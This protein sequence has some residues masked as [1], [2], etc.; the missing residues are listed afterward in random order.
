ME[1]EVNYRPCQCPKCQHTLALGQPV[2]LVGQRES[3]K[4]LAKDYEQIWIDSYFH[5]RCAARRTEWMAKWERYSRA[6]TRHS[7]A[8]PD[9]LYNPADRRGFFTDIQVETLAQDDRNCSICYE[10]M[11][12]EVAKIPC[13]HRFHFKC[14]EDWFHGTNLDKEIKASCPLCRKNW[15]GAL[16]RIPSW[17]DPVY[18]P[19]EGVED[20]PEMRSRRQ[21]G[22]YV[23]WPP[24]RGEGAIPQLIRFWDE[25]DE[26]E[27]PGQVVEVEE[28]FDASEENRDEEEERHQNDLDS[29]LNPQIG[30]PAAETSF[31]QGQLLHGHSETPHPSTRSDIEE[32]LPSEIVMGDSSPLEAYNGPDPGPPMYAH[33]SLD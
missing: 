25:E 20:V 1:A 6:Q 2:D 17:D 31:T 12:N 18:G 10:D 27:Y 7:I 30:S 8:E 5:P 14:I 16:I 13:G 19:A 33:W 21:I 15:K 9:I 3:W 22:G 28:D 23:P 11:A 32:I 4:A 26:V 24:R 29:E